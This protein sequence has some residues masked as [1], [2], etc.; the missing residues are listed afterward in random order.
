MWAITTQYIGH[1]CIAHTYIGH[2]YAASSS[3]GRLRH[4]ANSTLVA[5]KSYRPRDDDREASSLVLVLAARYG[6][7][8]S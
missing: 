3:S 7:N 6:P 5:D 8:K 1:N 4:R 2:S